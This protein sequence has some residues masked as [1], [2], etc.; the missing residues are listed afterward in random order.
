[1]ALR[2]ALV[3]PAPLDAPRGN[4]VTVA[5]VAPGLGARGLDLVCTSPPQMPTPPGR[6]RD[7]AE[8]AA[9]NGGRDGWDLLDR[10]IRRARLARR[11]YAGALAT[12]KLAFID[13][14]KDTT[15]RGGAALVAY[16][17][18]SPP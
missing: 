6:E 11:A 17:H 10:V 5:R 1:M 16:H 7:D 15:V 4:A 9:D 14:D 8:T 2:I 3:T 12:T 13:L 18:L